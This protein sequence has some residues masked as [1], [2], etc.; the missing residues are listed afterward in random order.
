MRSPEHKGADRAMATQ[1]QR[2]EKRCRRDVTSYLLQPE[3]SESTIIE[4]PRRVLLS[5]VVF[6][7]SV[8]NLGVSEGA[9]KRWR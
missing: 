1:R 4:L 2:G 7:L 5:D 3:L 8:P 6:A 9:I